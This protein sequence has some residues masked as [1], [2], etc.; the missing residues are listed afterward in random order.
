MLARAAMAV[1]LAVSA[2]EG[3]GR[4]GDVSELCDDG[5]MYVLELASQSNGNAL[6][7][8]AVL[9]R[10]LA[11]LRRLRAFYRDYEE[12]CREMGLSEEFIR[13]ILDRNST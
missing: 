9:R 13:G 3:Q 2:Q 10:A 6:V 4:R 7:E 5:D 11:D 8:A 1:S 12:S